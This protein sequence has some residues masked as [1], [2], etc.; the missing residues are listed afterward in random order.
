[1]KKYIAIILAIGAI[2]AS[3]SKAVKDDFGIASASQYTKVY[4]VKG[5][6]GDISLNLAIPQDTSFTVYA[7][8]AGVSLPSGDVSVT[9]G[10]LDSLVS[11]YNASNNT[12]YRLLPTTCYHLSSN[13]LTFT[14]GSRESNPM[15]VYISTENLPGVGP[16][17]LPLSI[18]GVSDPSVSIGETLNTVYIV[19]SG[20]M[21]SN[22]YP[23]Y[24]RDGWE[25]TECSSYSDIEI[26]VTPPENVFDG[27]TKTFWGTAWSPVK[28]QPPHVIAFDMQ[29]T[30]EVHGL[31]LQTR[32]YADGIS[33]YPY[34]QVKKMDVEVSEDGETWESL[35]S[36]VGAYAELSDVPFSYFADARYIRLTVNS[37]WNKG[38]SEFYQC[39]LSEIYVY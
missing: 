7:N 2:C 4:T 28:V 5:V 21:T 6:N 24:S 33:M 38:S 34:G 32:Y 8:M 1:M 3:C 13:T 10:V 25:V 23:N 14:G 16:F 22:T 37:C 20:T 18:V 9:F 11:S 31:R 26:Q 39:S 29:D 15:V 12:V 17:L 35:G 19:V 27:D 36:Y 30:Y